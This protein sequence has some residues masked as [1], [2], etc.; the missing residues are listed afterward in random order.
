MTGLTSNPSIFD[1]AIE[2]GD[3][4][5]AIR[6]RPRPG[7]SDEELFFDL[8]IEDLRRA[9]DLFLPIH[10]R[11]DGVDGWVSLEVSPLLAYDTAA[12]IEAAKDAARAGRRG[13]TCFIKIPG[14][15][16][17][18]ARDHRGDR[19]RRTGQRHAAVLGRPVPRP[20]P[21]RT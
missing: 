15:D 21:T 1:K 9:A 3:Y 20:P 12:T 10:E 2:S 11:T 16:R 13:P 14:T 17:G 19:G 18:P 7:S 8:A 5:D 6:G 4:D